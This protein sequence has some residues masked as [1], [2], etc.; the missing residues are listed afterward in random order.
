MP[1]TDKVHFMVPFS[2]NPDFVNRDDVI[3]DLEE[4]LCDPNQHHR[5]AITGIDGTGYIQNLD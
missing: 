5:V 2:R 4:R 3:D 1:E